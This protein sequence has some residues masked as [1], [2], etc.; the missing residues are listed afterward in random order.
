LDLLKLKRGTVRDLIANYHRPHRISFVFPDR[1]NELLDR[2][3]QLQ[4]VFPAGFELSLLPPA[5]KVFVHNLER[6]LPKNRAYMMMD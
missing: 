3:A 1:Y 6:M 5:L 4:P 2:V